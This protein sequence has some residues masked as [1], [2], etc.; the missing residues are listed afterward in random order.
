[1]LTEDQILGLGLCRLCGTGPETNWHVHAQCTHP[2]VVAARRASTLEI[3]TAIGSLE[4][5]PRAYKLLSTNWLL[6]S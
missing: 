4:L 5:P 3:F 2:D 6:D 1:M